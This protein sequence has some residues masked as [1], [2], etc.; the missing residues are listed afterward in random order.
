MILFNTIASTIILISGFAFCFYAG[1]Y[2]DEEFRKKAYQRKISG[3]MA[4]MKKI[5]KRYRKQKRTAGYWYENCQDASKEYFKLKKVLDQ[6]AN[7]NT[8]SILCNDGK[9]RS[10]TEINS[11]LNAIGK[12]RE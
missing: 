12:G 1:A 4:R 2:L 6:N 11:L 10:R 9:K 3:I 8:R 7:L 5:R